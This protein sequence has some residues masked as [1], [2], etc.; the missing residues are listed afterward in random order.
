M[1]LHIFGAI[2]THHGTAANNRAETEGNITTLQKLLWH[3]RV[4]STVSAEAIRFALRRR[5]AEHEPT[6]RYWDESG[7]K[8]ANNWNDPGFAKWAA[9]DSYIDDDVLGFMSAEA[10]KEDGSDP[11]SAKQGDEAAKKKPRAKGT[12]TI[13]RSPLEI[14]RA[15][16]LV[17]YAGDVTFNAASPGATPSAQKQGTNPVPYGTEVHATHYQYGFVLT[18]STLRKPERA[19]IVL[20]CLC[21]LGEV[22]GNHGRFL[23]DFSPDTVIFRV[24]HDPAPR[25]LYIFDL[26]PKDQQLGA[27]TLLARVESGDIPASELVIGGAFSQTAAAK[28]AKKLVQRA[29]PVCGRPWQF[30]A[31]DSLR[32]R[33]DAM[34]ELEVRVPVACFRK[35]FAREYWETEVLPPPST[36]YGFLLSLVGEKDRRRHIGARV[37]AGLLGRADQSTVLRTL[38]RAKDRATLPGVGTNSRPDYQELLTNVHLAMWLES[39]EEIASGESLESRVA[40]R[41]ISQRRS[42]ASVACRLAKAPTS[43]TGLAGFGTVP[44]I[45]L[46]PISSRRTA[47]FRSRCGSTTLGQRVRGTSPARSSRSRSSECRASTGSPRSSRLERPLVCGRQHPSSLPQDSVP[48]GASCLITSTPTEHRVTRRWDGFV[49]ATASVAEPPLRVMSLHAL[50]YCQRLFYL[51]EVEEIRV[52]DDRVY[53]GRE[54]HTSLAADEDGEETQLDLADPELGLFGKVDAIRRRDGSLL[55]YEH[56]RGRCR[57]GEGRPEAWPSDRLQV[58]AYAALIAS[59]TGQTVVEGRIRYHADNVTVRVP[60]DDVAREELAAAIATAR[61]FAPDHRAPAGDRQRAAVRSL[62]AG[63]RLPARGS[64]PG[65]TPGT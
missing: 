38:W 44:T 57:R 16:S 49:S 43:S 11:P 58:I 37:C 40:L 46:T 54:L 13:R 27:P 5:L 19:A 56:K 36:C 2:V 7:P 3:G 23:Y 10:A 33:G 22:A 6:N 8:P 35:G 29:N 4:H 18:P 1:S 32:R 21:G 9:G 28:Q 31:S 34:L 53:A 61:R 47:G 62:L 50:A 64:S 65:R 26:D 48:D 55:P 14:T 41:S 20:E 63:A 45:A 39:S 24:T 59:S 25:L 51:E 42:S 17:P 52:A 30:S 60:F 15:I 12:A